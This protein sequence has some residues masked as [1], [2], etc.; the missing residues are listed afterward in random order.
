[1]EVFRTIILPSLDLFAAGL[2]VTLEVTA[3]AFVAAVLLALGATLLRLYVSPLKPIAIVYIEFC[4]NTP[5]LVQLLWVNYVW[6][7]VFGWPNSVFAAGCTAL[8]LQTSGY[9]AETFRAGIEAV[10]RGHIE[11]SYALGMT[12]GRTFVRIVLPQ[13]LLSMSPAIMN[14]LL[15][16]MKSSTLV[17]VI[18]IPDLMYQ[19]IRLM[20]IW[21]Q[22]I[23]I[24]TFTAFIYIIIIFA[25]SQLLKVYTDR[26]RARYGVAWAEEVGR[27][28]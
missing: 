5:T 24:L 10:S 2:L 25:L 14:Q 15:I 4:R 9:L 7:D 8:A 11:A 1:M 3:I 21:Y 6:P 16:L 12:P 20:N 27:P 23:E 26:L 22:P 19:A 17:S 18:A 13:A 28:E